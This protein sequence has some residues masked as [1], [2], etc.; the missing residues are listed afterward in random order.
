MTSRSRCV[1]CATAVRQHLG[2]LA[3]YLY[4]SGKCEDQI[5]PTGAFAGSPEEALDCACN[6]YLSGPT[7]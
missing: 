2:L 1:G 6:L 7:N 4:S 3:L 5:L